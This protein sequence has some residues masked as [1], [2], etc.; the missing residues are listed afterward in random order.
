MKPK[1]ETDRLPIKIPAGYLLIEN[2][3]E[4][5]GEEKTKGGI[6]LSP[7]PQHPNRKAKVVKTYKCNM[8]EAGDTV[9][10]NSNGGIEFDVSGIVY[11]LLRED[12]DVRVVL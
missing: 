11:T 1:I 12:P 2:P 3:S 7:R 4:E 9:V 6:I 5:A 8:A 10:Y